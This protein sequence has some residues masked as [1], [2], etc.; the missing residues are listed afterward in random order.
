[1]E[2]VEWNIK[3]S[4][5]ARNVQLL[6]TWILESRRNPLKSSFSF[7]NCQAP[8]PNPVPLD[9]I[10]IPNPKKLKIQSPMGLGVTLGLV[11]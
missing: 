1:M 9:P 8:V 10:P 11:R 4:K 2:S 6:Q 3:G 7:L 5:R